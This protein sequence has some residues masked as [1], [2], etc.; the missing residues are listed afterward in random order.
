MH[1]IDVPT[2]VWRIYLIINCYDNNNNDNNNNNNVLF[3]KNIEPTHHI[4]KQYDN[5]KKTPQ[6]DEYKR[7]TTE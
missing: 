2:N 1:N 3:I 4:E 6:K 5:K 7:I